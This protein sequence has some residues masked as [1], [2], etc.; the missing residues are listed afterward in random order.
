M[1]TLEQGNLIK[2]DVEALVNTVNTEGVMG[3]GI[4]LQFKKAFP[5][6]VASYEQ[7][8]A[9]KELLPGG[10]HIYERREL[11]NPRYIINFATKRHW[12]EKSRIEYIECGLAQ[13]VNVVREKGIQ[14]I[15]IPALGCGN[16]GLDWDEV[17]PLI[18]HAFSALSLNV[19]VY[20]PANSPAPDSIVNQTSR[21]IMT[22]SRANVLQVLHRYCDLGYPLTLLEVHKLLYFLQEAGEPLKLRFQ[23]H[24]YGPYA[25]NLR[26]VLHLFEGH[27]TQGFGDGRNSP[28]T[29]ILLLPDALSE[30]ESFI[31]EQKEKN[32][33]IAIRLD[34]VLNLIEG[35]ESPYGMEL[36]STVHWSIIHDGVNSNDLSELVNAIHRW[37]PRK[38]RIMKPEHIQIAWKHLQQT[39]WL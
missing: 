38:K 15:A 34:R 22:L 29:P 21:P 32:T 11:L 28:D 13:L 30:A 36:L 16:G 23:R 8:C 27:F 37:N 20:P 6:M 39:G 9:D 3:K 1:I 5:E 7:A 35:F 10:L 19:L 24:V 2:A 18:Q 26:H 12:R 31:F 14:S 4:A 25:D 33:D 17:F